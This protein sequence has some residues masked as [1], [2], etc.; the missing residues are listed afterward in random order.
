MPFELETAMPAAAGTLYARLRA[1][2]GDGWRHYVEHPFVSL[3][4][5]GTLPPDEYA[6]WLAQDYLYLVHYARAY[7]LMVFKSGTVADMAVHASLLH[8]LLHVEMNLHREQL[9]RHGIDPER[10]EQIPETLELVAYSRYMLDRGM[11]GDALDL[12]V[13]LAACLG[14]YGEIGLRLRHGADTVLE[15]N[16]YRAWIEAYAGPAYHALVRAGLERLD[17]LAARLGSEAR[18]PLLLAQFREAVRFETAFWNAG[19]AALAAQRAL[20]NAPL[21][22]MLAEP[23]GAP[24]RG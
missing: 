2:A 7:A 13:T 19:R 16:R 9:A 18:Y 4:A 17:E 24:T 21:G 14:G 15:G 20:D 1:D 23:R 5:A 10:I 12:A 22:A 3:L 6:A 8:G 11:V